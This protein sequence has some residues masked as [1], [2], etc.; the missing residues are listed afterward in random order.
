M[1][2]VRGQRQVFVLLFDSS[3]SLARPVALA[4]S[5]VDKRLLLQGRREL[6]PIVHEHRLRFLA[7][8]GAAAVRTKDICVGVVAAELEL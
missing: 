5:R 4:V 8:G 3:A 2:L 7:L 6:L 1:R